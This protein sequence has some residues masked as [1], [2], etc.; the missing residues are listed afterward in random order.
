[1]RPA[2]I[3]L[4]LIGV[5]NRRLQAKHI[6]AS[7][8]GGQIMTLHVGIVGAGRAGHRLAQC[9]GSYEGVEL[10]AIAEPNRPLRD[11][12]ARTFHTRLAVSDHRRLLSDPTIDIVH[13]CSPPA[14]HSA[15]AVDSLEV[16]KHVICEPP[17]AIN[18]AQADEM[19]AAAQ[20]TTANLFVALS[21]KYDP[22]SQEA[23]RIIDSGEIDYPFFCIANYLED[24]YDRLNDWHDWEGTWDMA[25]GGILMHRGSEIMDLLLYLLGPVEGV[26]ALCTRFAIEPLNKAEDSCVIDLE[27]VEDVSAQASFTGAARFSTWPDEYR[28]TAMRLEILGLGGSISITNSS[29]PLVVASQAKDRREIGR[30]DITTDL[31]TDM[32]RNFFD[33]ILY[34]VEPLTTPEQAKNA[35]RIVLAAYKSSQ[36][37]RR[38]ETL[39]IL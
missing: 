17:I 37:K 33:S 5:W 15:I 27:F 25:G 34:D 29:P 12:F 19:L 3:L 20:R 22:I 8:A 31:P 2:D 18:I 24:D 13:I 21:Q 4:V 39:E 14:T 30:A 9:I 23:A 7:I 38:V 26:G 28:G 16:G 32:Y 11:T 35:L 10:V 36:M 6:V 1:M